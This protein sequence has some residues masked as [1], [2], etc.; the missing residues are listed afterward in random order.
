M[1]EAIYDLE[2]HTEER[3]NVHKEEHADRPREPEGRRRR[4][5]HASAVHGA[6]V[7]VA[8]RPM[9][10]HDLDTIFEQTTDAEAVRM[11]AFTSENQFDRGA[12]L[13]RMS[14]I[15]ADQAV[16]HRVIEVD[17]AVAGTIGSFHM[18]NRR[19]VTYWIDRR[20]WGNGIASAALQLLLAEIDE[21]PIYGR[22]ASDN[23][24]SLRVLEKAGFRRV[25]VDR[26]Y[27]PGRGEEIEET[28]LRLD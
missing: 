2:C 26:G 13:D 22:A 25:G 9:E 14:R 5:R 6:P 20:Q 3:E 4:G 24:G 10:D 19:E 16:W 23:A 1:A 8:L 21:R 27:A 17:G 28:I 11:A 12:F 15:R 7:N 18:D